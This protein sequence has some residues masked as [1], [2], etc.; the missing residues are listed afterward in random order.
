M[1]TFRIRKEEAARR[2]P[3]VEKEIHE[4]AQKV[5]V[6]DGILCLLCFEDVVE[7]AYFDLL[8]EMISTKGEAPG[9]VPQRINGERLVLV[10]YLIE[11]Y[12]LINSAIAE[13]YRSGKKEPNT[14]TE[15]T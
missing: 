10:R 8:S 6:S 11:E 3:L 9:I 7:N 13:L 5:N 4:L 2:L 15:N 14:I 12:Y 1:S